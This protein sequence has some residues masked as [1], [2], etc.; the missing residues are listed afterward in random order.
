MDLVVAI[1]ILI[2]IKQIKI[3]N[4]EARFDTQTR[5]HTDFIIV[6]EGQI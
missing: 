1:R 4:K 2:N 5:I 3:G 6:F